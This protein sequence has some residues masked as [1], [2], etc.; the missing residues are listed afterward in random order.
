MTP[1]DIR[2]RRLLDREHR[3]GQI[4]PSELEKTAAS[5]QDHTDNVESASPDME[6][7]AEQFSA[8]KALRDERIRKSIEEPPPVVEPL[9]A[10][11]PLDD[12]L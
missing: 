9:M 6:E 11:A 8:E 1:S 12:E 4:A 7:L 3:K 2:D 5:S 10:E